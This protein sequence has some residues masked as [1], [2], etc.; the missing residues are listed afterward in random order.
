MEYINGPTRDLILSKQ[1]FAHLAP[2]PA[3]LVAELTD[4]NFSKPHLASTLGT[5]PLNAITLS[6]FWAYIYG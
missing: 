3:C 6:L 1:G 4:I 5:T 2:L